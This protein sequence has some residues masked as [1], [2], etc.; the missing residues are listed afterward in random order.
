M[1]M[2]KKNFPGKWKWPATLLG[3]ALLATV[4]FIL[5][6]VTA[7]GS[8]RKTLTAKGLNLVI[9]TLDTTR[10]DHI[11]AYG[12]PAAQTPNLDSLAAR[13]ILFENCYSP[14]PVTLPAHCSLFTGKYPLGHRVRDN[15]TFVLD[16]SERTLAEQLKAQGYQTHAFIAAF[17]LLSKFGLNQGFDFYDDSL[18]PG[19]MLSNFDAEIKADQVYAKFHQWFQ[20]RKNPG[21]K[22]FTWIHFYDAHTPYDPPEAYKK[23]FGDQPEEL[24]NGEV[25]YVDFYLGKIIADLEDA[26]LLDRTLVVVA[27]DHGEAFGEHLEF[28]HSLFCY[29]MN[30]RVPLVFFT[31]RWSTKEHKELRGLRVTNRVNLVDIMPTL[32]EL[33][34]QKIPEDLQGTSFVP[35]LAGGK[36]KTERTFYAET[37]HGHEE[38]G[39]APLTA[40][41]YRQY[42]YISLP[43]PEL[44]DLTVD[45]QEKNNLFWKQNRL[46]RDLDK[47]LLTLVKT[48]STI[49]SSS[50]RDLSESDKRHLQTLGYISAFSNKT[51]NNIDPKKGILL[52]NQYKAIDTLIDNN[53]LENA[54]SSLQEIAR[55][56]KAILPQFFGAWDKIYQ[57]RND[58][59]AKIRNW[60]KASETFPNND[61]FKINLAFQFFHLDRLEESEKTAVEILKNNPKY[62]MAYILRGRIE[63]KKE[64]IAEALSYFE[65]AAALE[66]Q[67]VSLELSYAKLL[68]LNRNT[69]KAWEICQK[70][71]A[72]KTAL[73]NPE[74]KA[75]IGIILCEIHKNEL[76]LHLLT[77]V[78]RSYQEAGADNGDKIGAETWN[79]LGILYSRNGDYEKALQAYRESVRLD[80]TIAK[81]YN[82]LG[83]LYLTLAVQKKDTQSLARA[84]EAFNNALQLDPHL[85]SALNGRGSVFK[86]SNR[87]K[88]ALNDWIKAIGLKPDF[89]DAYFN[90]GVT[91]LQLNSK[92]NALFYLKQCKEKCSRTLAP[93]D[94][95]RLDRLIHE[96]GG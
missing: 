47:K 81:T 50:K 55:D 80:S 15:G 2:R 91:Y 41:I 62:T 46:A 44:Y 70:F 75:R 96:S 26:G 76:A 52:E 68:G 32:L 35:L 42:K 56:P 25:A 79:Y 29:E 49:G 85:V 63:E 8:T 53:Q 38:L 12:Y 34:E 72:D 92:A 40:I 71:L 54:Q 59:D 23:K 24:Y 78:V 66:P 93:G 60:Q 13:G 17:V 5:Y 28:G 21:E 82:N 95:Q 10:A 30:L 11:G 22:F 65:K 88:D 67:N 1:N 20:A 45:K 86:F 14:V 3:L 77:E 31:P 83:T 4:I 84:L 48:Y 16:E 64:H 9:I 89:S 87:S 36:E 33:L 61:N 7:G 37:M 73:A 90:I 18:N 39:W 27:G 6:R 51:D 58:T 94:Q 57:K 19:Q 74:V 69:A 43:E